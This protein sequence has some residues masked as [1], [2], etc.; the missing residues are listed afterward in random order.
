MTVCEWE[1]GMNRKYKTPE[2][3]ENN[4]N[5]GNYDGLL[6]RDTYTWKEKD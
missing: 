1:Q 4:E 6:H 2:Q 5:L 3:I